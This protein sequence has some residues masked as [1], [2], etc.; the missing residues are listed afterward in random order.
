[1]ELNKIS[2]IGYVQKAQKEWETAE[3]ARH[4]AE[5][6]CYNEEQLIQQQANLK[7]QKMLQ[8]YDE[9]VDHKKEKYDLLVEKQKAYILTQAKL[10]VEKLFPSFNKLDEQEKKKILLRTYNDLNLDN[11]KSNEP[12]LSF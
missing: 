7:A 5:V 4:T 11:N 3:E 9:E 1:M 6:L 12:E 2:G 10:I 8:D